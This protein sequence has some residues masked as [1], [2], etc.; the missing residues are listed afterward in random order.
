MTGGEAECGKNIGDTFTAWDRYIDGENLELKENEEIIQSWRTSEFDK[1]DEDSRLII[2]LKE[3]KN[4]TELILIHSN[5]PE[6]QTQYKQGWE[7]HY[8]TPM[9]N[10]FKIKTD[11]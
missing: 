11:N 4:G 10:Y 5:I 2:R 7:D 8:F 6:G 9:K 1:N 3:I